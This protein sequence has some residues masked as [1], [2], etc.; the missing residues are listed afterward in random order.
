LV[1]GKLVAAKL[2]QDAPPLEMGRSDPAAIRFAAAVARLLSRHPRDRFGTTDELLAEFDAIRDLANA[3]Q[4]APLI[5]VS[6]VPS[7]EDEAPTESLS[8][9]AQSSQMVAAAR[10]AEPSSSPSTPSGTSLSAAVAYQ[11]V[12]PAAR[13]SPMSLALILVVVVVVAAV[14]GG[15]VGASIATRGSASRSGQGNTQSAQGATASAVM[16]VS[17]SAQASTPEILQVASAAPPVASVPV[18]AEPVASTDLPA[19]PA[20][21]A[22]AAKAPSPPPVSRPIQATSPAP[23]RKPPPVASPATTETPPP[24]PTPAP[25]ATMYI[26]E[27]L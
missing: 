6:M 24:A 4:T 20:V 13:R 11:D 17:A 2:N 22:V 27:G 18:S 21:A 1:E 15:V 5:E 26:P 10:S 14:M 25:A 12:V 3:T 19:V 7:D 23:V 8:L 9:D 16:V